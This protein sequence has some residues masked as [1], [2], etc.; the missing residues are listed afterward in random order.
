[1]H[2]HNPH[3]SGNNNGSNVHNYYNHHS[4]G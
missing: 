3:K 1:M 4:G 2:S